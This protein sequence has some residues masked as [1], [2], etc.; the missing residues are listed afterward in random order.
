V[1]EVFR[2]LADP[3]RRRLLDS[4]NARDGQTL[5]QLCTELDITR[6][7]VSKHLAVLEA[8]N[9][10][11]SVRH[12]REKLH[13]LNPVPIHA[14]ADRW[15]DR[16][17]RQRIG[18]LA[19]LKR[20]LEEP[21]N[22]PAGP[23]FVYVTYINASPMRLWQALTEPAFIRRYFGGGGPESDWNVGDPVRWSM[24]GEPSHDWD[25]VVLASEPGR[26]LSYSWHNYPPEMRKYFGWSDEKFAEML[27]EPRSVVTFDIEPV[28]PGVKLTVSHT[29][30]VPDSEMYKGVRDGWPGILSG[31]KTVLETGEDLVL[32]D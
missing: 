1:D 5:R 12:G 10:V 11:T 24:E 32:A 7:S 15:M 30:F 17:D 19:D 21:V 29:G 31:L 22:T 14:I 26:K 28:G 23:E 18:A 8:A 16:Y 3:G 27:A 13:F 25:Q 20:V 9:L 2:A 4:L 6:Q